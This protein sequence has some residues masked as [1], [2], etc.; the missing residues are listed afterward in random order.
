MRILLDT[1]LLIWAVADPARLD[2]KTTD[3]LEDPANEILFSAASIWETAIKYGLSRPDFMH[4][5]NQIAR[6][7]QQT[8]FTELPVHAT[9]A[10]TVATLP[11]L[12]RDPFDRLLIAQAMAEPALF[13][14]ADADL[15]AY[16]DLVRRVG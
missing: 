6:A 15:T 7:A 8:G 16:S 14:T 4:E 13:Y 2:G 1:H 9:V 3:E 10:A 11:P 5:P 12:H